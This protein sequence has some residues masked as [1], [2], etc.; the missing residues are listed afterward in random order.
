[1]EDIDMHTPGVAS[2]AALDRHRWLPARALCAAVSLVALTFAPREA[3]AEE[4]QD[5]V[6]H[7]ETLAQAERYKEAL[8]ELEAAYAVRQS[9]RLVYMMAKMHQRLGDALAA[10]ASYEHFLVADANGDLRMR[11]DAQ[12]Q[13]T[14]LRRVLGKEPA[15]PAASPAPTDDA[16]VEARFEMKPHA[17]MVAGG[18]VLFGAAYLGAVATGSAFLSAG[19]NLSNTQSCVPSMY[20]TPNCHGNQQVAAGT[21]LIPFAG[22][23]IAALAYRDPTWSINVA[24]VDGVAQLGGLAMM[25]Y[26]AR[27]PRK[28][29]V[30]GERFQ[31]VPYAAAAGRGLGVVGRF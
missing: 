8:A 10:L 18:A 1:L 28:V 26:A 24:L 5:P 11:A 3:R 17:G 9:P 30:Y 16:S 6:A 15:Q 27:K 25:V 29:L 7:A 2:P 12:A 21:L 23:F 13:A 14:Q 31:V 19:N 20:Y 22:P 4:V